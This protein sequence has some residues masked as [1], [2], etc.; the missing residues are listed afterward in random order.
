VTVFAIALL[1]LAAP[2]AEKPCLSGTPVGQRPGPYSFLIATGPDRGK[3]ECFV[4][5]Q[6][7]KPTVIVF[8]RKADDATGLLLAAV[9]NAATGSG[10]ADLKCWFT[11][12]TDTADLDALAKWSQQHGLKNL[13]VGATE[14]AAGPPGYRLNPDAAV[15]VLMFVKKKVVVNVA[16]RVNEVTSQRVKE[17]VATLPRILPT[18]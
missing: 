6:D 4:C 11:L 8:G 5:A 1:T 3:Q 18:K 16:L 7:D 15:T 14:D 2:V 13:A 9:D 12:L 10:N 17:I